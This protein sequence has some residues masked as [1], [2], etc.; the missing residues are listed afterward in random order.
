[1]ETPKGYLIGSG[2]MGYVPELGRYILFA[3]ETE[4][5]EYIEEAPDE[6]TK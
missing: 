3:T 4:Y 1:M 2:Y 5:Y 6:D